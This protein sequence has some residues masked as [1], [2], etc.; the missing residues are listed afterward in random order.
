MDSK[1][2]KWTAA[3]AVPSRNTKQAEHKSIIN[4]ADAQSLMSMNNCIGKMVKEVG[5]STSFVRN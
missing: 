4:K 2:A 3:D 1:T 5:N